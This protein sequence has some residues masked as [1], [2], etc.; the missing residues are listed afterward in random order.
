MFDYLNHI[1]D[2]YPVRRKEEQKE[3]FRKYCLQ[4]TQSL[5]YIAKV[6]KIK[7]HNNVIIGDPEKA[8]VIFTAHYDTPAA[9]LFPNL[10]MPRNIIL[11]YLYV[12]GYPILLSLLSLAISYGIVNG[13]FNLLHGNKL[14]KQMKFNIFFI[15]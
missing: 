3:N 7:E 6:E 10:M 5:G 14:N 4:E 13:I 11:G 2:L 9:S 12:F 15:K 1:N 8:K